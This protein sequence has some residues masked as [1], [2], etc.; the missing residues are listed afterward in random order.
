MSALILPCAGQS[1]RHEGLP[2]WL[3]MHPDGTIMVRVA[4]KGFTGRP[5]MVVL[6]EHLER[7]GFH[8]VNGFEAIVIHKSESQVDTVRQ[9]IQKADIKGPIIIKDCDNYF[10]P[11]APMV[12]NCVAYDVDLNPG[13]ARSYLTIF[14]GEVGFIAEKNP[15]SNLFCAGAYG[16]ES[17]EEFMEFSQGKQ[18][19]SQVISC[20][21]LKGRRFQPIPIKNYEDYGTQEAW[22]AFLRGKEHPV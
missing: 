6:Q 21:L 19:I 11:Q 20:L 16:F 4:A 3:K 12:G 14:G 7:I 10:E 8:P 5:I 13:C 2:K 17:A 22:D 15:I 9:A 1:S 18:Y